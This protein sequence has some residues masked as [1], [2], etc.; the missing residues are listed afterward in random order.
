[1]L[2]HGRHFLKVICA[3]QVPIVL[4]S[5]E[6]EWYALTH[7][8]PAAL[9]MKHLARDF[10]RVLEARLAGD[11]NTAAG[12]GARRGVGKIHH[13]E[14]RSLWLQKHI[15]GKD[16]VLSRHRGSQPS[17]LRHTTPRPRDHG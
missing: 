16:I 5:A 13:L 17:R 1:M 8:A 2:F 3:A 9:G 11:S 4:S 7:A 14:T 12:I 6:S 10:G 15:T